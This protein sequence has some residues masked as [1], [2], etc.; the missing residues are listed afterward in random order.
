MRCLWNWGHPRAGLKCVWC[1]VPSQ[2][3]VSSKIN[4]QHNLLKLPPYVW[5]EVNKRNKFGVRMRATYA[6]CVYFY[7]QVALSCPQDIAAQGPG[8]QGPNPTYWDPRP[9]AQEPLRKRAGCLGA[10]LC[11]AELWRYHWT[12]LCLPCGGLVRGQWYY[13]RGL[14]FPYYPWDLVHST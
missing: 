13:K 5:C 8:P 10:T 14:R 6:I 7:D 11:C 3:K 2:T 9:R 12:T 4:K 1:E